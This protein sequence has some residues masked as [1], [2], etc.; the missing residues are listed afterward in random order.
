MLNSNKNFAGKSLRRNFDWILRI[1]PYIL[2][3]STL[4]NDEN[5]FKVYITIFDEDF[6]SE[7]LA[8]NSNI[9]FSQITDFT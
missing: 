4:G 8:A 9:S 5:I 2:S 1:L 3:V 7:Y 6:S